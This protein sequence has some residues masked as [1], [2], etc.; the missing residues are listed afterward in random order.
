MGVRSNNHQRN[1]GAQYF[2]QE[3]QVEALMTYSEYAGNGT[4]IADSTA[5]LSL[6][7]ADSGK[8]FNCVLDAAA[9]TVTLPLGA[10]VGTRFRIVQTTA[11]V[12]S[13]VLT[14]STGGGFF[15]KGGVARCIGKAAAADVAASTDNTLTI[16]GAATNSGFGAGSTIDL[17]K[18]SA[19]EW[20]I[21]CEGAMLGTGST[22]FA[23]SA[24]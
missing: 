6:D 9:K 23:F 16:T 5:A 4:D 22:A 21:H 12:A 24:V 8:I 11:L 3:V 10:G 1:G 2:D 18:V 14:I 20:W 19:T 7:A 17:V 15:Q 13:G